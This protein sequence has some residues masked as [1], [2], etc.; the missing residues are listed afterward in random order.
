M[1]L[2]QFLRALDKPNTSS[3]QSYALQFKKAGGGAGNAGWG[4]AQSAIME[5]EEIMG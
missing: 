1:V 4:N 2:G 5:I 3:S